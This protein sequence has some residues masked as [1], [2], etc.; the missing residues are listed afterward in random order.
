MKRNKITDTTHNL[1]NTCMKKTSLNILIL[2]LSISIG[3]VLTGCG[4]KAGSEKQ[5]E[6]EQ[7]DS[8][9]VF[10]CPMHPEVKGKDGE[11][12][13]ICGMKLVAVKDQDTTKV[14]TEHKH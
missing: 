13:S 8:V 2:I 1:N 10:A 6:S 9:A 3:I 7:K 14:Q 5:T 11:S 12:C 4:K